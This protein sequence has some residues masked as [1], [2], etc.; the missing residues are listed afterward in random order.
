MYKYRFSGLIGGFF[1]FAVDG[2]DIVAVLLFDGNGVGYLNSFVVEHE[3]RPDRRPSG[4]ET[5]ASRQ[6]GPKHFFPRLL[7][8]DGIAKLLED[9]VRKA[10][11]V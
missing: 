1:S 4:P 7:V 11:W 9:Q 5:T 3:T 2:G 6:D 8:F 10:A